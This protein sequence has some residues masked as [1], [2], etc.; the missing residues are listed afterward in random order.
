MHPVG[1]ALLGVAMLAFEV[2]LTRWVALRLVEQG[3]PPRE[4][5]RRLPR[6]P[7]TWLGVTLVAGAVSTTAATVLMMTVLLMVAVHLTVLLARGVRGLPAF[8]RQVRRMGDPDAWR[9]IERP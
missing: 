3:R 7:F 9:G 1:L 2:A 4:A 5:W 6:S 8:A